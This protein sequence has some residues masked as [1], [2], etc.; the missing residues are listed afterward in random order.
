MV[1]RPHTAGYSPGVFTSL[2]K[3]PEFVNDPYSG[4]YIDILRGYEYPLM[5]RAVRTIK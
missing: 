3:F 4:K 5:V 2:P 1:K